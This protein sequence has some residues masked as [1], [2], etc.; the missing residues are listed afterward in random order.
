MKTD[1][2]ARCIS[3]IYKAVK[4]FICFLSSLRDRLL[5]L[6]CHRSIPTIRMIQGYLC[7][8]FNSIKS[9]CKSISFNKKHFDGKVY[10]NFS[11]SQLS[12]FGRVCTS[13]KYYWKKL[14]LNRI[15][16]VVFYRS[17]S[18]LRQIRVFEASRFAMFDIQYVSTL[19]LIEVEIIEAR[20]GGK[21]G[22]RERESMG[23]Y[24]RHKTER[25]NGVIYIFYFDKVTD[26]QVV[27]GR[28][29][30]LSTARSD[31]LSGLQSRSE[32]CQVLDVT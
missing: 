6:C 19:L 28:V 18:F 13:I 7:F 4:R 3:K 26:V 23:K 16:P 9:S 10:K 15:Q 8:L 22:E 31:L 30:G 2:P 14:N 32:E 25:N 1:K 12:I 17:I 11:F 27:Q 21:E 29:Y 24:E 20:T 5:F